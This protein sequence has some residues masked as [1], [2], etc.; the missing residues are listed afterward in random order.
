[1]QIGNG[2]NNLTEDAPRSQ[3]ANLPIGQLLHVLA[4]G[5]SLDVVCDHKNLLGGVYQVMQ[6]DTTRVVETFETSNFALASFL[7]HGV[8][9]LGLFVDFHGVLCAVALVHAKTYLRV[10]ALAN[11]LSNLIMIETTQF[12]RLLYSDRLRLVVK[13]DG[14]ESALRSVHG[15][16]APRVE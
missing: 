14:R 7:L 9:E 16:D 4:Q 12:W 15:C 13:V 10:G 5:N 8:L 11:A 3:F 2:F 1:M 6:V